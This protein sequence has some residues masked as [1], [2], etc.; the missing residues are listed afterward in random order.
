MALV[1]DP[2]ARRALVETMLSTPLERQREGAPV[3]VLR[4]REPALIAPTCTSTKHRAAGAALDV[5]ALGRML[6]VLR[7]VPNDHAPVP[8]ARYASAGSLYP[9][10]LLVCVTPDR[11]DGLVGG[12]DYYHP[13]EHRLVPV[14]TRWPKWPGESLDR[15]IC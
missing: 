1:R 12:V 2:V 3:V 6:E 5:E 13:I 7:R 11:V 8:K 9:V 15:T 14:L 4:D 10:Q